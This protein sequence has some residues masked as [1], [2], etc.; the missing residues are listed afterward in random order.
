MT[1]Q[2]EKRRVFRGPVSP[3]LVIAMGV[4]A[5][6]VPASASQVG[7]LTQ[8]TNGT[9]ADATEVNANFDA[10]RTAVNDNDTRITTLENAGAPTAEQMIAGAGLS[11][12]AS[13]QLFGIYGQAGS[14]INTAVITLPRNGVLTGLA[15][16]ARTTLPAGAT[17][18]VNLHIN[19]SDTGTTLTLTSADGTNLVSAG[20]PDVNVSAGDLFTFRIAETNGTNPG[21][22]I[23]PV[24]FLQ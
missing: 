15:A 17:V 1:Q 11:P 18:T 14:A 6:L 9:T 23:H 7:T 13:G 19:G 22:S 21:T 4:V 5:F 2:N 8:F 16:R 10:I 24:V 20:G 12:G 3:Y